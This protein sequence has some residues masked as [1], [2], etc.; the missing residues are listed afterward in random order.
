MGTYLPV[1]EPWARWSG[2][3]LGSLTP[4]VSLPSFIHHMNVGPTVLLLLHFPVPLLSS[5]PLLLIWM[6]VTSL[7]LW[8]LN[9]HTGRFSDES[10]WY[11]FCSLVVIFAVV[12]C[13]V[14][15]C[16]AIPPTWPEVIGSLFLYRAKIS[17]IPKSGTSVEQASMTD[18]TMPSFSG[19]SDHRNLVRYLYAD[20]ELTYALSS[21][22]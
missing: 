20:M 6:N 10:G 14:E 4:E 11:L 21:W 7:N 18:W 9:Y 13:G 1:L 16:L 17:P 3:G 5:L 15:A 22:A 8:L 12:V 19:S 2:L